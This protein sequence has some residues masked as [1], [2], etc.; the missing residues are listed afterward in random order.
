MITPGWSGGSGGGGGTVTN[1]NL[2]LG[3]ENADCHPVNAITGLAAALSSSKYRGAYPS[4]P[5]LETAY[6]AD[7]PGA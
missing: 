6:P 4:L 3:R 1:H 2:L 5:A 7:V